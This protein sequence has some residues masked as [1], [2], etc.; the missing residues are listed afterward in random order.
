LEPTATTEAPF[1]NGAYCP[2]RLAIVWVPSGDR[3]L[4]EANMTARPDENLTAQQQRDPGW[5]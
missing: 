5:S 3:I 2:R 1:A 4:F